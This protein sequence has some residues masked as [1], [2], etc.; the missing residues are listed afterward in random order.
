VTYSITSCGCLSVHAQKI[1][2]PESADLSNLKDY[3][4]KHLEGHMCPYC[5]ENFE[6][7]MGK[8]LFYFT[9]LC[10]A[11]DISLEDILDKEAGKLK[12]LGK[13]NLT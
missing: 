8:V 7:E 9:A 13:F 3:Y 11:L 6:M 10:N 12:M 5:L 4:S 1:P 2:I